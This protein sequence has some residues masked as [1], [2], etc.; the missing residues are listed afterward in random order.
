MSPIRIITE[1][2]IYQRERAHRRDTRRTASI[3]S[4][5]HHAHP[6]HCRLLQWTSPLKT[7][8]PNHAAHLS[9]PGN[10]RPAPHQRNPPP[11]HRKSAEQME[12]SARGGRAPLVTAGP[13]HGNSRSSTDGQT[14]RPCLFQILE[15]LACHHTVDTFKKSS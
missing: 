13:E 8:Y 2:A 7:A 14:N 10:K 4:T 11:T 5:N 6:S 1:A 15:L 3:N 12:L 9:A